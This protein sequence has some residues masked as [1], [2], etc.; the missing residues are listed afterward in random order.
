MKTLFKVI[1][2]FLINIIIFALLFFISDVLT[3]GYYSK[4]IQAYQV[5]NPFGY[6]IEQSC[7]VTHLDNFFDGSNNTFMGRKPDGLEYKDKMPV[8]VF[9]CSFAYGQYLNYNQTFTYKLAHTL[10]RPVYNRGIVG[11][12]F[13]HMYFQSADFGNSNLFNVVKDTDTVIYIM[14]T[15]HYR[16]TM[17]HYFN[18]LDSCRLLNYSY[19]NHKFKMCNNKLINYIRSSYTIKNLNHILAEKYSQNPRNAE[20][21]TD[22]ALDYFELSRT[23]LEKHYGKKLKFVVIIYNTWDLPHNK[24]LVEKLKQRNYIVLK[25]TDLIKEDLNSPELMMENLHPS[26]KAWDLVVSESVKKLNL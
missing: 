7:Y 16:R 15:D 13:Q 26:E 25:V 2:I 11:G 12:S 24:I 3:Y 23:A 17:L 4:N 20:E 1:F 6:S 21:V 8:I 19:K 5:K 10:K 22:K 14:I 9:G 18:V